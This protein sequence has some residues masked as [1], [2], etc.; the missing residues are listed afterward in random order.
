MT[1]YKG[2]PPSLYPLSSSCI[3]VLMRLCGVGVPI[4]LSRAA[5][6]F[7]S[8]SRSLA[9]GSP[10]WLCNLGGHSSLLLSG[11]RPLMGTLAILSLGYLEEV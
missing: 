10:L 6:V 9:V 3:F 4:P 7:M 11:C 2:D 8:G 5:D 1:V